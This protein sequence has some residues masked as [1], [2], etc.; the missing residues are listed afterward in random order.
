MA[1]F[2]EAIKVFENIN[3][4]HRDWYM[5]H[6]RVSLAMMSER[7]YIDRQCKWAIERLRNATGT[8][9]VPVTPQKQEG[10]V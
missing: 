4:R 1:D 3:Q 8:P 2:S 5:R 6:E 7:E 10:G 9:G